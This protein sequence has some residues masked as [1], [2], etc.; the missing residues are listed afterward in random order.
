MLEETRGALQHEL[1]DPHAVLSL[2]VW[3]VG[4]YA[5]L[6]LVPE[7]V[8]KGVAAALT[9]LLVTWLGVDTFWS[10]LEGWA[11]LV[12]Q[13][14]AAHDFARLR[15]AADAF[16]REL[17]KDAARALILGVATLTGR[18]LGELATR[19][20]AL[21]EASQLGARWRLQTQGALELVDA[22]AA[23]EALAL[24]MSTVELVAATPGG[25]LAV[26]MLKRRGGGSPPGA[27]PRFTEALRH[28]EGN[29]QVVLNNGQRW[30]LPRGLSP[31]RIPKED[32]VGNQL[33]EAVRQAA[34]A[35]GP[36]QLS[37]A[38]QRAIQRAIQRGEH[39]LARLLEREARGRFVELRVRQRVTR[40]LQWNHHGV[41]VVDPATGYQYEILSGTQSNL[42]RHGRRMSGEFF[43]M[44]T[45]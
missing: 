4:M 22:G 40:P 20:K 35:W 11:R 9:V 27:S 30:H 34:Q 42:A 18:T 12:E 15:E 13:A 17:G 36:G 32:P 33:Q 44:L 28:R 29:R 7:P 26:V 25:P 21:P 10:L 38:E 8:T 24:A 39:W 45:F 1:L 2:L 37:R 23:Q 6:W 16:A 3:T 14:H 41:D 5:M 43:R 31:Q 19:V